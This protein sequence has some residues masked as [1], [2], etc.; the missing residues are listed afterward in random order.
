V[1]EV[2]AFSGALL[3]EVLAESRGFLLAPAERSH[4]VAGVSVCTWA[5]A[6]PS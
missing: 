5:Q 1:A 3:E 6:D 4:V 2:R